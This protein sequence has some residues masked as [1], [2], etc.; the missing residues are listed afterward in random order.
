MTLK[1]N[2]KF[3]GKLTFGWK[4]D[5][6]ILVNFHASSRKSVNLHF[7]ALLLSKVYY[8]LAKKGIEE[9]CVL[10]LKNDSKFEEE[11]TCELKNDVTNL[12]NFDAALKICPLMGFFWPKYIMFEQKTFR[13]VMPHY[14]EDQCELWRKRKNGL[15]FHKWHKEFGEFHRGP[16]KS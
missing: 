13:G 2:A 1:G 10:T 6:R 9:L 14:T 16:Q 7:H 3:N 12:A 15:W 8:V 11:L 5:I 4:N